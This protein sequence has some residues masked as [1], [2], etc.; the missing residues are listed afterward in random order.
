MPRVPVVDEIRGFLVLP[1]DAY[2][3]LQEDRSVNT[4]QIL[5]WLGQEDIYYAPT[6]REGIEKA[7]E[8]YLEVNVRFYLVPI[9]VKLEVLETMPYQFQ[10]KVIAVAVDAE[11]D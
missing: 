5:R 4:A 11:E 10:E 9:D 7:R 8:L 3:K 6:E 2:G 1:P